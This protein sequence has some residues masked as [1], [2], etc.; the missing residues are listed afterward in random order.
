MIEDV[1][2]NLIEYA[3]LNIAWLMTFTTLTVSLL[4]R[5]PLLDFIPANK[6]PSIVAL[7]I[8]AIALV[9]DGFGYFEQFNNTFQII[10]NLLEVFLGGTLG[11]MGL[12]H[13]SRAVRMPVLQYKRGDED[14]AS[15]NVA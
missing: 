5:I 8:L 7:T 13:A 12:Y 4:K 9:A 2:G 11:S 3:M 6:L 10:T 14:R 1:S 15:R